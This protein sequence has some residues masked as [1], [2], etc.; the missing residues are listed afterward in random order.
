MRHFA[1]QTKGE[2]KCVFLRQ[3]VCVTQAGWEL[4]HA[5]TSAS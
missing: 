4:S 5:L 2:K 3:G 1:G